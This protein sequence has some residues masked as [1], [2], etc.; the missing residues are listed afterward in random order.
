MNGTPFEADRCRRILIADDEQR[1]LD[2]YACVL[3]GTPGAGVHDILKDLEAD[4]F[5]ASELEDAADNGTFDVVLCR[6][7]EEAVLAVKNALA[8][9]NPFSVAFLDVRMPPG[10]D[11][12]TTAERI[13]A[14]DSQV[15]IVFVTGHSDVKVDRLGHRVPPLDK[16]LYCQKPLQ[17]AELL[18]F[19]RALSSKWA[20]EHCVQAG[21][22]RLQQLLT[23]TSVVIYSHRVTDRPVISFISSNVHDQFGYE[24]AQFVDHEGFWSDQIHPEDIEQWR[25]QLRDVPQRGDT[26]LEYRF[27]RAD[28]TFRWVSDHVKPILN[29][30]GEVVEYIGCFLDVTERRQA[31]E[32]IRTLALFDALTGLPNR[33]LMRNTLDHA[34]AAAGRNQRTVAVLFLD[35]DHFKRINDSLGHDVGDALLREVSQRLQ[36]CMRGSDCLYRQYD[37]AVVGGNGRDM[38]SRLGG[39]EFVIILP[40][41]ASPDDV[42]KVAQ[43]MIEAL[44]TPIWLGRDQVTVSASIGISIFPEDGRDADTLLKNADSAM[45]SAKDFGRNRFRFFTPMLNE[46][47]TRRFSLESKLRSALDRNEFILHYQPKFDFRTRQV[48]GVE[49]LLRWRTPDGVIAPGEFIPLAEELGLILPI[50]EWALAAA[51]RQIALWAR[52][53]LTDLSVAVNLSAVQFRQRGLARIVRRILDETGVAPACLELELT[54]STLI[55]DTEAS[56]VL[57]GQLK[58]LGLAL[59]VDDFGTGYSSLSYLRRLP[60]SAL[61]IDRSFI[62]EVTSDPNDATIVTA[63]I[64]LAHEL[65][66]R[67]VA[68]GVETE[69]QAA[70]LKAQA[71]DEAQGFLISPPLEPVVFESWLRRRREI[72]RMPPMAEL[73]VW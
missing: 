58:D 69:V 23:S 5:G 44:V 9:G 48:V 33:S 4:L 34:L 56:T 30:D 10:I 19:A 45:Y 15:N 38:I 37:G 29:R 27:R 54:E 67:V 73:S 63:T 43:R 50:G 18:Q 7:G 39:D 60:L 21:Q 28:G 14:L 32:K 49:A 61:K 20:A 65:R 26:S 59:S 46:R 42:A 64:R 52:A 57:L 8:A 70:F 1:I 25:A 11:G 68:E 31:E 62:R 66:L 24:P 40:D 17:S 6:Q 72:G 36:S 47:A 51:C 16:L 41:I 13:R 12:V 35:L 2:E 71:C 53:G 3:R 55:E 22:A